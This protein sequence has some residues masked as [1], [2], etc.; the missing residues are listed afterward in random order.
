MS[1]YGR[2]RLPHPTVFTPHGRITRNLPL[3][4]ARATPCYLVSAGWQLTQGG[5]CHVLARLHPLGPRGRGRQAH[6][7][8]LAFDFLLSLLAE[9]WSHDQVLEKYPQLTPDALRAVF[10]FAAESLGDETVYS[11]D[12]GTV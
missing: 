5:F 6:H 8:R 9:G 11:R 4:A 1:S 2:W 7:T 3:S 10:A 12:L